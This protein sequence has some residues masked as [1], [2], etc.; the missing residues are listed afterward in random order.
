MLIWLMRLDIFKYLNG[1]EEQSAKLEMQHHDQILQAFTMIND[2]A[3]DQTEK[4]LAASIL[5]GINA[6][7]KAFN[8]EIIPDY[9]KQNDLTTNKLDVIGPKIVDLGNQV[10]DQK[11][12]VY[13]QQM[14]ADSAR[15]QARDAAQSVEMTKNSV[16]TV[17]ETIGGREVIKVKVD[18]STDKMREMGD[19]SAQIGVIVEM[20]DEI[21]SQTNRQALNAAIE[22][23]RAGE[24]GKGFAVFADEVRKLAEKSAN[25]TKDVRGLVKG[26]QESMEKTLAGYGRKCSRS[27]TWCQPGRSISPGF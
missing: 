23:A 26:I 9:V 2:Y 15:E 27:G 11:M 6:Y 12:I 5:E 14:A 16:K 10:S 19:R 22:A 3:G 21:A 13:L 24:H 25:A 7:H 20:I 1:G 8:E 4:T 17:E 18:L